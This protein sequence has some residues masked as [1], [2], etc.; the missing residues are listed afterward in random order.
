[1]SCITG[2][3]QESFEEASR[4]LLWRIVDVNRWLR[5]LHKVK[6]AF[7]DW[8]ERFWQVS[9]S[10]RLSRLT[11]DNVMWFTAHIQVREVN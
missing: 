3:A 5:Q 7:Q 1:M 8:A 10:I 4:S 2:R 6:L 11:C 9:Y